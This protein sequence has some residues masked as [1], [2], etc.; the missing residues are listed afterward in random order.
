MSV[1]QELAVVVAARQA[2]QQPVDPA[3]DLNGVKHLALLPLT[4]LWRRDRR[5]ADLGLDVDRAGAAPFVEHVR[6]GI[7]HRGR[8]V[9]ELLGD[10]GDGQALLADEQ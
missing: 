1:G 5:M 2:H 6:V 8:L 4:G 10:L 3:A 7:Q 9:A